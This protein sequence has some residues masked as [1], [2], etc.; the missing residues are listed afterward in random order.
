[1]VE[2]RD[3]RNFSLTGNWTRVKPLRGCSKQL[4]SRRNNWATRIDLPVWKGLMQI[5]D[6]IMFAMYIGNEVNYFKLTYIVL[7][8]LLLFFDS[9]RLKMDIV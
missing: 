6:R 5:R 8:I 4:V 7:R 3:I 2:D 1:M 9:P